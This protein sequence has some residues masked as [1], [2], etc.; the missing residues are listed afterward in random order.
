M[1]K[2]SIIFF[3]LGLISI[4]FGANGIGG[5]SIVIGKTFLFIFL[6]LAIIGFIGSLVL[7]K[8]L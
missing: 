3:I 2:A 4:L 8:K 6:L 7:G 1:L 5:M